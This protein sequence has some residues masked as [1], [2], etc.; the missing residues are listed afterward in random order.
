LNQGKI[1]SAPPH[2]TYPIG[3]DIENFIFIIKIYFPQNIFS[4][5]KQFPEIVRTLT[6]NTE[7]K[8]KSKNLK[9][10]TL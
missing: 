6:S 5:R 2:H 8:S 9:K 1:I 3:M 10:I 7:K 4:L